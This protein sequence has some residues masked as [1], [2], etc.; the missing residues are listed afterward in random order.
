MKGISILKSSFMELTI[1]IFLPILLIILLVEAILFFYLKSA[2]NR[3]IPN[4]KE[5]VNIHFSII[6]IVITLVLIA[7]TVCFAVNFINIMK[8][9]NIIEHNKIIYYII[10]ITPLIPFTYIVYLIINFVKMLSNNEIKEDIT[11]EKIEN[12]NSLEKLNTMDDI[13]DD[14]EVL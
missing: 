5:K 12:I 8:A 4:Y 3:D 10:I 1:K 13:S 9:K 7:I 2:K 14:I 6:S 11:K